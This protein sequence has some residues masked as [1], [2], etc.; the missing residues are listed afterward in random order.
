[1][2]K[3]QV[4]LVAILETF[5]KEECIHR[6]V[7]SFAFTKSCTDDLWSSKIWVIWDGSCSFDTISMSDQMVTSWL[8]QN[9]VKVLI[10]FVYAK[11]RFYGR[12][13]TLNGP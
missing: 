11:Y 9:G 2:K 7:N 4:G 6:F 8:Y 10:S 13:K 5:Q 1:M 3:N 12:K